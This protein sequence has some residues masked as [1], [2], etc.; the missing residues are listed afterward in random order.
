MYTNLI[1]TALCLIIALISTNTSAQVGIGTTTPQQDLH[2][3]GATSTIRVEGLSSVNNA[4]NNG[5]DNP[6]LKVNLNGD[7]ILE[8]SVNAI[9]V[10]A[11]DSDT[12]MATPVVL[13]DNLGEFSATVAYSV[14]ITLTKQ[15]LVE[16][17]FWTACNLYNDDGTS[18]IDDGR[19]RLFG[20]F[21]THVGTGSDIVYS[22]NNYT[23]TISTGTVETGFF[24]IGGNGYIDLPA[25]DHTFELLVFAAGGENT[26]NGNSDGYTV[27]FGANAFNRFQ[28][29]YHN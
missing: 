27:T 1:K 20:G 16:V 22:A 4:N 5:I 18:S 15:T 10:D 19:V 11:S 12:F 7:L 8:P 23:N 24:T 13:S 3:A 2:V 29:V 6:V 25:G 28:L 14:D 9:Q 26:N 21:V 17:T